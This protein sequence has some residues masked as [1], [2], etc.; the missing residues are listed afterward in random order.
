LSITTKEFKILDK[1]ITVHFS[2]EN[3]AGEYFDFESIKSEWHRKKLGEYH[4]T[5]LLGCLRKYWYFFLYPDREHTLEQKGI[6]L[7]GQIFHKHIQDHLEKTLGFV[8]IECPCEDEVE[9]GISIL[10]KIDIVQI[11]SKEIADIKTTRYMPIIGDLSIENF[12]KKFG[13]YILQVLAQIYFVNNTYFKCDPMETIKILYIDKFNLFTKPIWLDYDEKLGEYFYLK[14]RARA[15]YL[16]EH[17]LTDT[18]PDNYDPSDF[19]V[20]CAFVDLCPEGTEIKNSLT[21]P[22]NFES[23]EFKKKYGAN[24]KPYWKYDPDTKS[25]IKSKGFVDFLLT[26]LKYTSKQLEEMA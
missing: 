25:W 5:S 17:I 11:R 12:E 10:F 22:V 24:K 14:I 9:D 16:H 4:L 2:D 23:V 3:H 1:T 21:V 13:K 15:N 7:I 26:E 20:Y 8:I 19:C 18:I 6:F